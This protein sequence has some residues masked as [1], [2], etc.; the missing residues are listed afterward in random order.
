MPSRILWNLR[1]NTFWRLSA[2]RRPD[3]PMFQDRPIWMHYAMMAGTIKDSFAPQNGTRLWDFYSRGLT[4][5]LRAYTHTFVREKRERESVG[6]KA[7]AN[8]NNNNNWKTNNNLLAKA[9]KSKTKTKM[10]SLLIILSMIL[11]GIMVTMIND[12]LDFGERI[13]AVNLGSPRVSSLC[14]WLGSGG[15]V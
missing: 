12:C 11:V 3:P 1:W 15:C 5:F 2:R 8:N 6:E 10:R 9:S 4:Q 14:R 13:T 7:S